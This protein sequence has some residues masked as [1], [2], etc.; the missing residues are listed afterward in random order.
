MFWVGIRPVFVTLAVLGILSLGS[1]STQASE[2][3]AQEQEEAQRVVLT[4]GREDDKKRLFH[5]DLLVFEAG[6]HYTLVIQ[7]PSSE[8]HEFDAPGLVAAAWSSRV[9]S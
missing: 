4:L 1:M 7:N 8:V 6:K 5:P 2:D 3:G 9:K